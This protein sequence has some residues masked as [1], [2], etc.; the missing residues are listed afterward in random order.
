MCGDK[1]VPRPPISG[2]LLPTALPAT[3][4]VG[5]DNPQAKIVPNTRYAASVAIVIFFEP[6]NV[7]ESKIA[8]REFILCV[9]MIRSRYLLWVTGLPQ[10]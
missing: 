7:A 10:P 5:L 4:T 1:R 6:G 2:G 9:L 8:L 3:G